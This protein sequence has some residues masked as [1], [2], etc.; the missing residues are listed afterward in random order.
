MGIRTKEDQEMEARS[1]VKPFSGRETRVEVRG[2]PGTPEGH[3]FSPV[4][5]LKSVSKVWRPGDE[6]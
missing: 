3:C 4:R 1:N 6:V 2:L 5:M